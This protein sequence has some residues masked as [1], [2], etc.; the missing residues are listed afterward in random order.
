MH[1][2]PLN[3][4]EWSLLKDIQQQKQFTDLC[5]SKADYEIDELL[6]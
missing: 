4:A 1:I 5:D 2:D 3:A 6:H